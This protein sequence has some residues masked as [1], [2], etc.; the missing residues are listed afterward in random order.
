MWII[1]DKKIP[2]CYSK[3]IV[4]VGGGGNKRAKIFQ[5]LGSTLSQ[6]IQYFP[7]DLENRIYHLAPSELV[8][9][10]HT[11]KF[12]FLKHIFVDF[13]VSL[14]ISWKISATVKNTQEYTFLGSGRKE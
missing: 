14:A 6:L 13:Y 7:K 8:T 5:N 2:D 1:I 9:D 12:T 11:T 3:Y 4:W 10:I